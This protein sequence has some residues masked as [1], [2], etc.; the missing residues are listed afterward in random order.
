VLL[1]VCLCS[2]HLCCPCQMSE[3][4]VIPHSAIDVCA[5]CVQ[6]HRDENSGNILNLVM[7][8]ADEGTMLKVDLPVEFK[9]EDACPGLKKGII[10][11]FFSFFN[12]SLLCSDAQHTTILVYM[13]RE[14]GNMFFQ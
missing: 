11:F 6:V 8:K 9:G 2:N 10:F 1:A 7:V 5:L 4:F 3:S 12:I 13:A 14:P